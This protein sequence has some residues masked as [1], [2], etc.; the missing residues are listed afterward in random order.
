MTKDSQNNELPE[1]NSSAG[2]SEELYGKVMQA[3]TFR[4]SD[5]KDKNMQH[6]TNELFLAAKADLR[7]A[8]GKLK[9]TPKGNRVGVLLDMRNQ[10]ARFDQVQENTI[11]NANDNLEI[12]YKRLAKKMNVDVGVVKEKLDTPEFNGQYNELKHELHRTRVLGVEKTNVEKLGTVVCNTAKVVGKI[13]GATI[14]NAWTVIGAA[15]SV[16]EKGSKAARDVS[17]TGRIRD[18]LE[19]HLKTVNNENVNSSFP[20]VNEKLWKDKSKGKRVR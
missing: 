1:Y 3:T 6:L 5:K 11:T 10:A 4:F 20:I 14:Y 15:F 7:A 13:A 17:K 18:S 16:A 9:N 12:F 2:K 19:G 8:A